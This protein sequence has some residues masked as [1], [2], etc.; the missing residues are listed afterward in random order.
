MPQPVDFDLLSK[1]V[2][3]AGVCVVVIWKFIDAIEK[4]AAKEATDACKIV[5]AQRAKALKAID[6]QCRI[7]RSVE[8]LESLALV[9]SALINEQEEG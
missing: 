3:G 5:R 6:E 7:H 8:F 9:R 1:I 2:G 4:S